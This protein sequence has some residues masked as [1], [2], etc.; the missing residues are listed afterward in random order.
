M[1]ATH[2]APGISGLTSDLSQW[3][4]QLLLSATSLLLMFVAL[5]LLRRYFDRPDRSKSSLYL[6]QALR[7][8]TILVSLV[9]ALVVL[10]IG[11]ELRDQLL[12]LT[13]LVLGGLFAL[14]SSTAVTNIMGGFVLRGMGNFRPGD[15][16]RTG[17]HFGR[18]SEIGLFHVEIQTED[19][20]LT[21]IPNSD[22]ASN[23][24]TVIHSSGTIISSNVSLGYDTSHAVVEPLLVT[25]AE[26]AGLN[27]PFVQV[28]ELGDYSVS[29]RVAGFF[30]EVRFLLTARSD[31]N[32]SI[33][34]TLHAAGIE[35]MSPAFMNQRRVESDE[36]VIPAVQLPRAP[37]ANASRGRPENVIFDKAEKA[38]TVTRLRERYA[39]VQAEI[40]AMEAALP[41][42]TDDKRE[43]LEH[44]LS[45]RRD[46][47][48]VLATLV[49]NKEEDVERT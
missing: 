47:A 32:R 43:A 44:E 45:R 5:R 34:K 37:D 7:L 33:L 30:P 15:F 6:H 26:A 2:D 17:N 18:V 40:A 24:F 31:L 48:T 12:T 3:L 10:P 29:Y 16:I 1:N 9:L 8:A 14:A 28:R 49:S 4:P 19:R 27:E 13:G 20:D 11:P 36:P 21:T 25:A 42:V 39:E 38:A 35:I 41:S 46:R 22:L 23:P